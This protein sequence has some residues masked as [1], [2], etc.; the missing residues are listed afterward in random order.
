METGVF[1]FCFGVFAGFWRGPGPGHA[2]LSSA[3]LLLVSVLRLIGFLP[4]GFVVIHDQKRE[5][6]VGLGRFGL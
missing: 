1:V 3:R 4:S 5:D 2:L 6:I